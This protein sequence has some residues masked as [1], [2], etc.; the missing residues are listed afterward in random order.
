[1]G[2]LILLQDRESVSSCYFVWCD[3][4]F[5]WCT[6]SK[7]CP[8]D[9]VLKSGGRSLLLRDQESV[10]WLKFLVLGFLWFLSV[11]QRSRGGGS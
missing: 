10:L 2:R 5:L 11:D 3:L 1:V 6:G 4:V 7:G 9:L 8:S